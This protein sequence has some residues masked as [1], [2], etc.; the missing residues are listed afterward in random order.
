MT[1][2]APATVGTPPSEP[3]PGQADER[4]LTTPSGARLRLRVVAPAQPARGVA[5][6][7]VHGLFTNGR[8]F[9]SARGDGPAPFFAAR[10]H[11]AFV[12]ELRRRD[13]QLGAAE[14]AFCFDDF[15]QE[16]VPALI[17]SVQPPGRRFVIVAHSMGGYAALV[18]LGLSPKLQERCAGVC[19]FSSAVNDF[20][21]M[22]WRKRLAFG[23][24]SALSRLVGYFPARALRQGSANEPTRLMQQ[25][26]RWARDGAFGQLGS[27]GRF[28]GAALAAVKVPVL[29]II[30]ARDRFHA[31][32][33]RADKLLAHVGSASK[34]LL[35]CGRAQGFSTDFGHVD[36]VRGPRAAAEVLPRVATWL[37]ARGD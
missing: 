7:F 8:F 21:E 11:E 37:A 27:Q 32:P 12:G 30:G 31:S 13:S 1:V 35:L 24:A 10:G 6:L 22:G 5:L 34:E 9:A 29:S 3:A 15:V 25:L 16:D 33:A 17:A 18:A 26:V 23:F 2:G 19:L 20:S 28:P 14:A 36:V 4:W